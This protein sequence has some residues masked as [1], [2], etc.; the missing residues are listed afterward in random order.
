LGVS[1]FTPAGDEVS[2]YLRDIDYHADTLQHHRYF[3][4]PEPGLV[5]ALSTEP[6]ALRRIQAQRW[7]LVYVDGNHDYE[8][9][10]ADY[11]VCRDSL[12]EGGLLVMDDSS[13][14]TD[15]HP[16]LFSFAGH[17]GPSRV[18]NELAM[19]ELCFLGA[20]GHNNVFTRA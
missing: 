4:L 3:G 6:E 12:S 18:V 10:L 1:P 9:A 8:V 16:R 11:R 20:V 19:E 13:L 5:R 15:Y 2:A 14:Y 7:D 17:P